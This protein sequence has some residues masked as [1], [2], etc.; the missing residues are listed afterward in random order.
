MVSG[1]D[2]RGEC[3]SASQS[4]GP[5][6]IKV[7]QEVPKSDEETIGFASEEVETT[8]AG[9]AGRSKEAVGT[10]EKGNDTDNKEERD[11]H[12]TNIVGDVGDKA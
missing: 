6:C 1:F 2:K 12:H 9:E 4:L 8:S 3:K 5:K 11:G 7:A 10:R